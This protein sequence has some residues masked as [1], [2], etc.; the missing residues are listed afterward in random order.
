MYNG[1]MNGRNEVSML[2][3]KKLT[4]FLGHEIGFSIEIVFQCPKNIAL[5]QISHRIILQSRIRGMLQKLRCNW[6]LL[7]EKPT[8]GARLIASQN[9]VTKTAPLA[10]KECDLLRDRNI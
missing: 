6:N 10:Y 5:L 1:R 8:S 7:I 3:D 2:P 9:L 4:D